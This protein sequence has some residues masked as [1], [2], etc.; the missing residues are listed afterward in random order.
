M[1]FRLVPVGLLW[2]SSTGARPRNGRAAFGRRGAHSKGQEAAT[3]PGAAAS[4]VL[5][6]SGVDL[7]AKLRAFD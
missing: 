1:L 4:P 3:A 2:R 5:G 7:I 6:P